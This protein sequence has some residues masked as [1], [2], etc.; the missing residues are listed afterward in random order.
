MTLT[1]Q[2]PDNNVVRVALQALAAVLGG[3]QSLHTNGK[4]EALALPTEASARLALRTQQVIALRVRASRTPSTRSGGSYAVEAATDAIERGGPPPPRPHRGEG[5]R[6]G[7][8]R[9]RRRCSARSRSRRTATS[10]E[11]ESRRARDRRREP[12]SRRART[13]PVDILRIDPDLERAQVE[14]VR[15]LRARRDAAAWKARARRARGTGARSAGEPDAGDDRRRAGLGH[16]GGDRGAAARGLRRAPRDPRPAEAAP[17]SP[18]CASGGGDR[19]RLPAADDLPHARRATSTRARRECWG[20]AIPAGVLAARGGGGAARSSS[21]LAP[22]V[23]PALARSCRALREVVPFLACILIYTNLHDTIGFVNPHD[24]HHVAGRPRP[25]DLRR[26][27]PACGPSGFITPARTEVMSVLL[28]ELRLDRAVDAR[29][30]CSPAAAAR[31]S[32]PRSWACSMCFYLG[33][34]LYVIFPAAPPRLVLVYEF[35]RTLQ[36]LPA[37]VLEPRRRE[38]FELLPVD[39]RAAFP[40][41]HAAVSLVALVYAWRYVRAVVLG[42]CCRSCWACGSRRS[43][44][45]TTTWWT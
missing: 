33:Y 17:L 36:R 20:P 26:R 45:A 41:L 7:R 11:V 4:D 14:R 32:G 35:T 8:D 27:S 43:T 3:C 12:S 30:S 22:L 34:V 29:S 44:C 19:A 5:R 13:P 2:Q 18:A 38:A 42:R 39:S 10:S 16:R 37:P 31:S 1:A 23:A 15:A 9:A 6:A 28:P 40:S 25:P 24:V 21:P